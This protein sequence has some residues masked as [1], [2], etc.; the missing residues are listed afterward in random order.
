MKELGFVDLIIG[1]L[2]V[3]CGFERIGSE[4]YDEL[5][6]LVFANCG[7]EIWKEFCV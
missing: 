2:D 5:G 7:K 1:L 4:V 6:I 3:V